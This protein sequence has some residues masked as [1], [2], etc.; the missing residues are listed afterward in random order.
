MSIGL[1][2]KLLPASVSPA[3]PSQAPDASTSLVPLTQRAIT[4]RAG[5]NRLVPSTD[6][7]AWSSSPRRGDANRIYGTP[8]EDSQSDE[9]GRSDWEYVSGWAWSRPLERT[10]V[11]HYLSYAASLAGWSGRLIN[12]FA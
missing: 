7:F 6:A 5:Q 4:T 3:D 8:V 1:S 9:P 2:I 12:V 10:A 11:A